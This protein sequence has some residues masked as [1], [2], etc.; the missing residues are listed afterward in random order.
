MSGSNEIGKSVEKSLDDYFLR[1][2]GEPPHGIYD[3]V[4]THVERA[5]ISSVMERAGGNQTQAADMLGLNRS[6]LRS[7]L[8]K[9]GIR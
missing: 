7:K 8:T 9:Y 6:T 4:I 2:D 1:L 3:M 5:M